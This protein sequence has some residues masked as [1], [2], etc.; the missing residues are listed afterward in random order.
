[1]SGV[2][3]VSGHGQ[4]VE[5]TPVHDPERTKLPSGIKCRPEATPAAA[6]MNVVKI[7]SPWARCRERVPF[8]V[9]VVALSDRFA[10]TAELG[11][12]V[13]ELRHPVLRRQHRFRVAYVHAGSTCA[14]MA[15]WRT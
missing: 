15:S 7:M 4:R 2:V 11:G 14:R 3:G 5:A 6:G 12:E 8:P 13:A 10:G 1:M 9:A